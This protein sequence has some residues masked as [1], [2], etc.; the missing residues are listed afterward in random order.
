MYAC[1][2]TGASVRL[3]SPLAL[4]RKDVLFLAPFSSEPSKASS[5]SSEGGEGGRGV[6]GEEEEEGRGGG[7]HDATYEVSQ[8][9]MPSAIGSLCVPPNREVVGYQLITM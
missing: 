6:V 7:S 8:H 1:T 9:C 2:H 3:P 5:S 4:T